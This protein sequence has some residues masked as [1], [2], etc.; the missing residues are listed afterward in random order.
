MAGEENASGGAP[1]RKPEPKKREIPSPSP[2]SKGMPVPRPVRPRAP[3]PGAAS[4]GVPVPKPVKP[5]A[6]SPGAASR[7]EAHPPPPT[8]PTG[9]VPAGRSPTRTGS[10]PGITRGFRPSGEGGQKATVGDQT[11]RRE[12]RVNVRENVHVTYSFFAP[13]A[14][15]RFGDAYDGRLVDISLSGAQIEGLLPP[16]LVEGELLSGAVGV[17][18][19]ILPPGGG[20]PVRAESHVTWIKPSAGQRRFMGLKFLKGGEKR[21]RA[22][23]SFLIY[24]Q[25]PSRSRFR[26]GP[27]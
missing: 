15:G 25:M 6:P 5:K 19:E 3:S 14:P 1:E 20:E 2:A 10:V 9:V 11:L 18:A 17:R 13:T 24:L 8:R 12:D 22:L 23:K 26:S 7:G 27:G 4:R 21:T 16:G